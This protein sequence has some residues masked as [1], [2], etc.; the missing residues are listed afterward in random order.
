MISTILIMVVIMTSSIYEFRNNETIVIITNLRCSA[1]TIVELVR[2][3][4]RVGR[5]KNNSKSLIMKFRD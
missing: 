4:L 3:A 5:E 2:G 1:V